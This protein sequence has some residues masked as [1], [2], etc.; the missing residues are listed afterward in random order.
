MSPFDLPFTI[1][2]MHVFVSP[3]AVQTVNVREHKKKKWMER[4]SYAARVQK[5]WTKRFGTKQIDVVLRTKDAL[6][7]TTRMLERIKDENRKN[8]REIH[9]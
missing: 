8:G 2:G 5:K 7:M 1:Y 3:F 4:R 9:A 6:F